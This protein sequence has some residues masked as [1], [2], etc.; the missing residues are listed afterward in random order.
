MTHTHTFDP[1]KFKIRSRKLFGGKKE[2]PSTIKFLV[3]NGFAKTEFQ[4][5]VVVFALF[6][7]LFASSVLFVRAAQIPV[8]TLDKT[9]SSAK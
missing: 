5:I 8:A 4:A 3:T 2:I 6:I 9:L 7:A 1:S